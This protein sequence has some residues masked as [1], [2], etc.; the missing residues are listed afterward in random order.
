MMNDRYFEELARAF[1]R[2]RLEL[3]ATTR[4]EELLAAAKR[5]ALKLH[6]FKRNS[7][8]PRVDRVIGILRGLAP[9]ELLDRLGAWHVLV[10]AARRAARAARNGH[11]RERSA[12]A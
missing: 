6:K 9:S 5:H 4:D 3:P 12:G 2:G 7:E 8:L 1:I 11:R 10:A